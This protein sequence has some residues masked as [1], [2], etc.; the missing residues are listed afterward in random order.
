VAFVV[1]LVGYLV[2][3]RVQS[4]DERRDTLTYCALMF[5]AFD[6]GDDTELATARTNAARRLMAPG[7][8]P[9]ESSAWAYAAA[10]WWHLRHG[11]A[12]L[13]GEEPDGDVTDLPPSRPATTVIDGTPASKEREIRDL[14]ALQSER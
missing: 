7:P 1:V 4:E 3:V 10:E 13:H 2:F 5:E 8:D 6:A 11:D 12:H 14:C 9:L